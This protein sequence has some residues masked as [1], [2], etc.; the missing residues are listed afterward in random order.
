MEVS[1]RDSVKMAA[2]TLRSLDPATGA[3][4]QPL[5]EATHGYSEEMLVQLEEAANSVANDKDSTAE[6][7]SAAANVLS[8][9][10]EMRSSAGSYDESGT[11]LQFTAPRNFTGG[12]MYYRISAVM[13]D[14]TLLFTVDISVQPEANPLTAA[15]GAMEATKNESDTIIVNVPAPE[16]VPVVVG[17][18]GGGGSSGSG[19]S[20]GSDTSEGGDGGT[21]S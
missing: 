6:A 15:V 14:H 7:V 9:V 8:L 19:S 16:I 2:L 3:T 18:T 1:T 20:S 5:L 4:G 21:G 17:S 10:Q 11:T 13:P 12:N